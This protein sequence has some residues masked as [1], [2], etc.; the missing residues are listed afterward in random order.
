MLIKLCEVNHFLPSLTKINLKLHLYLVQKPVSNYI[1]DQ[2]VKSILFFHS[3]IHSLSLVQT[4]SGRTIPVRTVL[5]QYTQ[6]SPLRKRA[7]R[8]RAVSRFLAGRFSYLRGIVSDFQYLRGLNIQ[9][10][11][12]YFTS[13]LCLSCPVS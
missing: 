8:I 4:F 7:N 3:Q 11:S 6:I 10:N 1:L 13:E 2:C 12:E 5:V 9:K